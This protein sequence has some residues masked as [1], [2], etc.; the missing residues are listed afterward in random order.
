MI[1]FLFRDI[2]IILI[3]HIL[4]YLCSKSHQNFP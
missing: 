2:I 1:Y 3:Y 4:H